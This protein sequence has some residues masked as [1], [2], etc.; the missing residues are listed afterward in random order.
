[1]RKLSIKAISVGSIVDV[2]SSGVL[3]FPLVV[4]VL[5]TRH[6]AKLPQDKM[7]AAV[8]DAIH[9]SI[10]IYSTQLAIGIACA[11]LGGYVAGK[12]AKHDHVLNG[13]FSAIGCFALGVYSVLSGKDTQPLV[14]QLVLLLLVTPIA[15]AAGGYLSSP[16]SSGSAQ[17]A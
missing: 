6:L 15:A 1:M 12:I 11:V 2:V 16:R 9:G 5:V 8:A 17:T 7:K 3:G 10:G 4:Y 13:C 14:V